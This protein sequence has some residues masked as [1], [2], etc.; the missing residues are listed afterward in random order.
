MTYLITGGTGPIGRSLV[1]QLLASGAGVRVTTRDAGKAA[2]PAAVQVAE[3]NF[4]TGELPAGVFDGVDKA[5]VFPALGGID[6]FLA[7]VKETA[8]SQ[9]VLLSSLAVALEHDRDHG[10]MSTLHHGAIERAVAGTGIPTTVLRPGDMANNLLYWAWTIKTAGVVYGPY[11]S[12]AQAPI[13][14]ADVAAV[15]AAALLEDR[16]AGKVYPMTGPEALTRAEML[17]TIGT[18]IGRELTFVETSPEAFR[19]QMAEYMPPGAITMLLDYWS[20]TVEQPDVPRPTVQEVTGLPARTLA[21]WAA[22]HA[23]DFVM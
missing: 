2:L 14:E 22:D 15:A 20:D 11:P 1:S 23:R 9:L 13:H 5:F 7:R 18:A 4:A 10:S 3:G 17:A 6:G 16:H 8:V 21:Q 12:S 19:Q